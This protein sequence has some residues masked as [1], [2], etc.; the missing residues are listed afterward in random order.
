MLRVLVGVLLAALAWSLRTCSAP[1]SSP[2]TYRIGDVDGRFGLSRSELIGVLKRAEGIWEDAS[3]RDLFALAE[4][5]RLPINLVYD[6]RQLTAQSNNSRMETI[7]RTRSS[8]G[9]LKAEF[10]LAAARY[11]AERKRYVAAQDAHNARVAAFNRKVADW[12]TRGGAPEAERPALER[13]TAALEVSA[14]DVEKARVTVNALADRANGLSTRHNALA[15]EVDANVEAINATA[16]H[17]FKQ[18]LFTADSSGVRIDVFEYT[19]RDDLVHVL[20]H[21]LGHALG[22][23]HNDNPNAIM[24]GLSSTK[25]SLLADEDVIALQARCRF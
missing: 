22:L 2:V 4:D 16:G 12:N 10:D 25:T 13:E 19:D 17:E 6:D 9:Q 7:D 15:G 3:H 18:G 14:A 11:E 5:G 20:A 24:Y 23:G 8:A 1:C 21:E